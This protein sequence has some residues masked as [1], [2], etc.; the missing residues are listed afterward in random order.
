[1]G[2]WLQQNTT[3]LLEALLIIGGALS[4]A[5]LG[6]LAVHHWVSVHVRRAHNDVAGF[7]YAV[8]GV[9]Y[10]ILV[11]LV[12]IVVWERFDSASSNV[13]LEATN[14][15]NIYHNVDAF[16]DPYRSDV[17]GIVKAYVQTTIDEEWPLLARGTFSR[18]AEDLAGELGSAIDRLP[19]TNAAEQVKL[20]H[21]M[22]EYESMASQRQLRIFEGSAGL[23]PLIWILLVCGAIVTIGFTYFFGI[24]NVWAHVAMI[25][26]IT[27]V[28][29]G[30]LF[31]I[32]QVNDP[33][34]GSVSV[35]TEAL[36]R[37][38]ETFT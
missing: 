20:D 4:L 23:H 14:L 8:L 24:D 22:G 9:M 37:V 13:D 18:H 34:A 15:Y 12:T 10:A 16:S 1:M 3:T 5:V 29:S 32:L 31:V 35:S 19:V 26:A 27:F 11:A 38:E 17:Q 33:F 25:A 28:I 21:L 6:F 2:V 7:I 30:T 36:R